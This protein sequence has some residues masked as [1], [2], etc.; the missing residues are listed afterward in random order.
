VAVAVAVAVAVVVAVAV[1]GA[2]AVVV[3]VAVAVAVVVA[4]AVAVAVVR[5][6]GVTDVGS[7]PS[8]NGLRRLAS[9]H[10]DVIACARADIC[11][12]LKAVVPQTLG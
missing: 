8:H 4:M 10:I 5:K 6:L 12:K 11:L 9:S 3:A 1:A 7:I 2:A